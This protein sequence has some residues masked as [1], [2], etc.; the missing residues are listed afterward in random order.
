M[1]T[2]CEKKTRISAT[3]YSKRNQQKLVFWFLSFS[4]NF[5]VTSPL[6]SPQ[7]F[8]F[9]VVLGQLLVNC[10]FQACRRHPRALNM[11]SP[12]FLFLLAS[13]WSRW[14]YKALLADGDEDV[15]PCFSKMR[16]HWFL[17]EKK[18]I[19][20]SFFVPRVDGF[21]LLFSGSWEALWVVALGAGMVTGN[22]RASPS[23]AGARGRAHDPTQ[24]KCAVSEIR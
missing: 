4:G 11:T 8:M 21:I 20:Y 15:I 12:S 14:C 24:A 16:H 7:M 3:T 18:I 9:G 13:F 17:A 5:S 1:K 6:F 19:C 22:G 23:V 10:S 2:H